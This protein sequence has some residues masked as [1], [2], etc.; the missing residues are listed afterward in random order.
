MR[1]AVFLLFFAL[2]V[3]LKAQEEHIRLFHAD[4][5]VD[6]SGILTVK[7]TIEVYAAGNQIKRGIVRSLPLTGIDY[8]NRQVKNEYALVSVE[9]DGRP[10]PFHTEKS[11]GNL[12][13]YVGDRDIT[14]SPG[15]YTYRITYTAMGQLGFFE[16]YDEIYWNVNGFGW[17]FSVE[18]IGATVRI[19][20]PAVFDSFACY[21]GYSGST[22]QNCKA[23]VSPDGSLVFEAEYL[24]P[25][26]NLTIAAGF[27][28]GVVSRPPPPGFWEKYGFLTISSSAALLLLAYYFLTWLRFGVDPPQP[29]VIPE[30]DPPTGMS[31]ASLGMIHRGHFSQDLISTSIVHLAVNGYI[32]INERREP[33]LFGLFHS[34]SFILL[35]LK[36]PDEALPAE[37]RILMDRLFRYGTKLIINGKYSDHIKSLYDSF[38][39]SL[40]EQHQPFL[41][42]G[43]NWLLW[44]P[45]ILVFLGYGLYV[46]LSDFSEISQAVPDVNAI[47][48][49]AFPLVFSI[50]A[51]IVI[52]V[53][54]KGMGK[55]F[56]M[57][58][59]I[60][61]LAAL[62]TTLYSATNLSVNMLALVGFILFAVI[63]FPAYI[64]LIRRPSR[65]K[66]DLR[67]R[68][69]GF[70]KYLSAA[71]ERQLQMFNPPKM[72]PDIF[73]K[74]LPFAMALGVD[75]IWGQKFQH[76]MDIAG[77]KPTSQ[78]T[79]YTSQRAYSYHLLGHHISKAL[80]SSIQSSATKPS[81]G[82]SGSSG[83][84]FSG[85]GRG[86]GG[87]GGW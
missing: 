56:L 9:R 52:W 18:R 37:E 70:E 63:S 6:T 48:P 15:F 77:M 60:T 87:G 26:Q 36:E 27:T 51:F 53:S 76:I 64:Y 39:S 8:R 49:S 24:E 68:I 84:G 14:L 3:S 44:I 55:W 72:T 28:K 10:E 25:Y 22:D 23:E 4:L 58:L 71:E 5:K 31:P 1:I 34:T 57:G 35:Q 74:L 50:L 85:G 21:T 33:V 17:N 46:A 32:S 45:P 29:T 73:E 2:S 62:L 81:S 67:A 59:A 19:P 82:G 20:K 16:D 61:G 41:N 79:W 66:L 40:V 80:G 78:T 30:F 75:K 11:N 47:E 43:S 54:R 7:E 69:A 86:G 13:I 83:G 42:Q 65:E 38:R 12:N